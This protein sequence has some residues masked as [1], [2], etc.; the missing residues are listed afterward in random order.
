M[1]LIDQNGMAVGEEI[2]ALELL[3]HIR[4]AGRNYA[5]AENPTLGSNAKTSGLPL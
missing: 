3:V 4:P 1:L 2:R 5:L